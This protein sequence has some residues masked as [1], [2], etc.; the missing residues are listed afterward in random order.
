MD[1]LT[2]PLHWVALLLCWSMVNTWRGGR[3]A[4]AGARISTGA[5]VVL[6]CLGWQTLPDALLTQLESGYTEFPLDADLSAYDGVII[7]GGALRSGRI[8]LYHAQPELNA[9]ADRMTTAVAIWKRYPQLPL[10]FTGGE[11]EL[12]G[13]GPTEAARARAFFTA[14]GIPATSVRYEDQSRTTY[15]NAVFSARLP[16]I[17][18]GKRWLLLTSAWHMPRAMGVFRKA[19]WNVTAYPVD[20][21]TGGMTPLSRYDIGDANERWS[22]Y[23]HELVGIAGYRLSGK[24]P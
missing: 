8:S 19:G 9:Q 12:F 16:G 13:M 17:N 18:P 22:L 5:C 14:M 24:M 6:L 1:F 3:A 11:G 2:H 15:E 10:L 20:F 23:L 21:R 7:L 4:R